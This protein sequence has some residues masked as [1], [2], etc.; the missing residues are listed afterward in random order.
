MKN[1]ILQKVSLKHMG[2][3]ALIA[4]FTLGLSGCDDD[5]R[6]RSASYG[7]SYY[8]PYDY[9]YYP[10]SYVYFN[11]STRDYYYYDRDRWVRNRVLPRH[12][13]LNDRGR[14]KIRD[15]SRDQPYLRHNEHR[16]RYAPRFNNV[17]RVRSNNDY[18]NT[19]RTNTYSTTNRIRTNTRSQDYYYYPSTGV[20]YNPKTSNYYYLR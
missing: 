9:Y 13:H 19:R 18:R 15:K 16:T 2:G 11:I 6:V 17:P 1:L 3:L 14:V 7:S 10:D 12:Y 8:Q 5:V 20:Y 4:V